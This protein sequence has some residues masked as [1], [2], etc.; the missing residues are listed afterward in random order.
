LALFHDGSLSVELARVAALPDQPNMRLL[1][2]AISWTM[3]NTLFNILDN[4]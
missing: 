3:L 4:E 1:I 2:A